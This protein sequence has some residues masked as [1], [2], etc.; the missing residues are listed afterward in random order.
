MSEVVLLLAGDGIGPEVMNQVRP[1]LSW[2]GTYYERDLEVKEGL[3][4]GIAYETQ[5]TPLSDETL[6]LAKAAKG[7][8]L[9]AVGVPQGEHVPFE[10]RP[11][12]GLLRLRKELKVFANLRPIQVFKSLIGASPL[13][14]E[15]ICGLDILI[16]RELTSGVYF[17]EPRGIEILEDGKRRGVNTQVY[18]SDE[19]RRVGAVAFEIARKRRKKVCSVDKANIMESGVLWRQEITALH[20]EEFQD[21][22]LSH[23][24]A[25]NCSMQ[26]IRNP[27]QFD[28]IVTDNL[29]GDML[30]DEA[31]MVTGSL[32]ML[33]S[34][35]IGSMNQDHFVRQG[36]Y[37]PVHGSAPD[38]AGQ[39]KANP[40]AMILSTSMM[41]RYS[42]FHEEAADMIERAVL[43][44]LDDGLRTLDIMSEGMRTC[45]T[46]EM[47]QAVLHHLKRL[48]RVNLV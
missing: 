22:Q 10:L 25:D 21:I 28:V 48:T 5:G 41:L 24:Y 9:G 18:T 11:E 20:Q 42:F 34:A 6:T 32:G 17:G 46:K 31:A 43:G 36:I 35:S 27:Q 40:L 47:G 38:I 23:M 1:I 16:V 7:V 39:Q 4:G 33:P 44:A 14:A 15:Y 45:S 37:E 26:L 29:F 12:A 30:S 13:R 19:I 8:L 2:F 3:I